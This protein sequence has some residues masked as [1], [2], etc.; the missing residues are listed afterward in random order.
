MLGGLKGVAGDACDFYLTL[1]PTTM[2]TKMV[3]KC[4]YKALTTIIITSIKDEL[5]PHNVDEEVS[6]AVWNIL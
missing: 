5:I 1:V 4:R 6:R 2:I 3:M